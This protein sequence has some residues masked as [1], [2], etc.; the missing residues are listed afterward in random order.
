M[1][2]VA[3]GPPEYPSTEDRNEVMATAQVALENIC[4]FLILTIEIELHPKQSR[5]LMIIK[6]LSRLIM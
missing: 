1:D 6:Q 2:A 5:M 3:T 4:S